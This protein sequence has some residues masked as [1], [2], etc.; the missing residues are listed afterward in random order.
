[1]KN[2]NVIWTERYVIIKETETDN[3]ACLKNDVNFLVA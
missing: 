1:M 2:V 3:A